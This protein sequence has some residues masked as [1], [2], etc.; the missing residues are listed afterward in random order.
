MQ[1]RPIIR[2]TLIAMITIL[3]LFMVQQLWLG[4]AVQSAMQPQS[5]PLPGVPVVVV[6]GYTS[7]VDA[8]RASIA[9]LDREIDR[10]TPVGDQN[11]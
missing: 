4:S 1:V 2:Q 7:Q 5:E 3:T 8:L 9:H 6:P 11:Q 10:L